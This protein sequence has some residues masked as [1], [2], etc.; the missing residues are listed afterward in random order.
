MIS[1]NKVKFFQIYNDTMVYSESD[2]STR[3]RVL[4]SDLDMKG[5]WVVS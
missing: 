4:L 1:I 2:F 5:N 3:P